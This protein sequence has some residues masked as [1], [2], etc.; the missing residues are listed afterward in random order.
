MSAKKIFKNAAIG[1]I[2]VSAVSFLLNITIPSDIVINENS[3]ISLKTFPMLKANAYSVANLS[4]PEV[5][6]D[7]GLINISSKECGNFNYDLKLMDTIP[8]K[9]INVSVIPKKYVIPSGE[10]IGV[11]M[12][13]DGLLVVYVSEVNGID[14][15]QYTPARDA[16][17][18]EGDR[19]LSVDGYELTTN[20][21]FSE[22]I[23]NVKQ[24]VHLRVAR[25]GEF[26]ETDI[27]PAVSDDNKY[28]VGMWVRDSTAGIGTMTYYEPET[29]VYAALGHAICD[30]DTGSI[31]KISQGALMEC[32]IISVKKGQSGIP[33]ELCGSFSGAEIGTI[34]E[35]NE[36]G[37]YGKLTR[38]YDNKGN[39]T[40]VAT[41][42]QTKE[43]PAEILCDIDGS[44][45]KSY[46]VEITKIS[47]T[48]ALDNKGLVIKIVD[49]GLLEKTG[50]IVQGMSG[51]PILQNGMLVG[52]VTHVFVND[53]TRGYGI[54]AENMIDITNGMN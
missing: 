50:G 30:T 43:G 23:N 3:K 8:I 49:G 38:E 39:L 54:F 36:F 46:P 37:I 47:K 32:D 52:A 42:F 35:N 18:C 33:G 16:G 27:V 34:T 31:L 20:E 25:E 6:V 45:V 21:E 40:E 9:N 28:K 5:E 44:G 14:G 51:A 26:F 41:R 24:Q 1:L 4:Q 13:T 2:S 7:N 10:S 19:I 29:N 22:Y 12:Y 17:L 48:A 53:P 11:K 15:I